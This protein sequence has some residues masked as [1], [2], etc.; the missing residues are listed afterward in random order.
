VLS[1]DPNTENADRF[2]RSQMQAEALRIPAT[3]AQTACV[4][5]I[6]ARIAERSKT[7]VREALSAAAAALTGHLAE[8]EEND[9]RRCQE[10]GIDYEQFCAAS[11]L[12]RRIEADRDGI[13]VSIPAIDNMTAG[14]VN[15]YAQ[16][17]LNVLDK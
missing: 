7:P 9:K 15:S 12:R 11:P 1:R 2:I 10:M 16:L 17:A 6:Q 5:A 14:Q 3:R 13:A 4:E 8:M